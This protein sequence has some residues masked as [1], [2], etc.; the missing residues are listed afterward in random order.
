ML[1]SSQPTVVAAEL[2]PNPHSQRSNARCPSCLT[3]PPIPRPTRASCSSHHSH[4]PRPRRAPNRASSGRR[5]RYDWLSATPRRAPN[6]ASSG[7]RARYECL[8]VTPAAARASQPAAAV[9][10]GPRAPRSTRRSRIRQSSHRSSRRC[11]GKRPP[12]CAWQAA[13]H[14]CTSRAALRRCESSPAVQ[15]HGRGPV[16][17]HQHRHVPRPPAVARANPCCRTSWRGV[18]A[19]VAAPQGPSRSLPHP[20]PAA[21]ALGR[22]CCRRDA[23]SSRGRGTTGGWRQWRLRC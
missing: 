5:V 4:H 6:R 22:G 15:G 19:S 9:A 16:P 2:Q 18:R 8:A 23:G 17:P 12:P 1:P 7:R 11:S 3:P 21:V 20:A 14:Q 13:H 10:A